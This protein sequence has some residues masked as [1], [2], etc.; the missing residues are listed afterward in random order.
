MASTSATI[1]F[2]KTSIA[3]FHAPLEQYK[4]IV[5]F[6]GAGNCHGAESEA[7][8]SVKA[9]NETPQIVLEYYEERR[10]Q[11]RE[12]RP[13]AAHEAIAALARVKGP[14]NF[15][16]MDMNVD[17]LC[18]RAGHPKHQ[19][20]EMHG[21]LFDA[22]C[23]RLECEYFKEEFFNDE[24]STMA[25]QT[26]PRCPRCN[27]DL[28]P[29]VVWSGENLRKDA[30]DAAEGFLSEIEPI[31]LILVIGTTAQIWPAAGFVDS[32]IEKG[33]SVAMVNVDRGNLVPEGGALGLTG[34]DWFSVGD[35]ADVVPRL[36]APLVGNQYIR[37]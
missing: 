14:A 12:A 3:S 27:S 11:A 18:S 1:S 8:S 29:A 24:Y 16:A 25:R 19:L 37:L 34:K 20:F 2:P 21:N 28:R 13:N 15:M 31:D 33:A 6:L 32:A 30:V 9:F 23:S 26:R 36:L 7:L 22:K 10:R 17:G 35:P 4:R 5:A